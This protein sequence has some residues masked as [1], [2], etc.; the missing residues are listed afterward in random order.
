MNDWQPEATAPVGQNVLTYGRS[1][2]RLYRKDALGQWRN[3]LGAPKPAPT[4]WQALTRPDDHARTPSSTASS[5][6]ASAPIAT[7]ETR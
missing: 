1:G 6:A 4:H 7:A 3:M 5:A 2:H